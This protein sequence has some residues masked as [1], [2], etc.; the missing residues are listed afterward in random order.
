MTMLD[1]KD[2]FEKRIRVFTAD[3]VFEG[4]LTGFIDELDSSSKKDE[5]ELDVGECYIDID[6]PSI[7]KFEAV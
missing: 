1:F 2:Y 4:E 6:I 5:I 7:L 3:K